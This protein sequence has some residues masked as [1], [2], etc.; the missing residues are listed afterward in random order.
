MYEKTTG[1]PW[2]KPTNAART[3]DLDHYTIGMKKHLAVLVVTF[4]GLPKRPSW[5]HVTCGNI[6][7]IF[8]T[9]EILILFKKWCLVLLQTSIVTPEVC[10]FLLG[11]FFLGVH[12]SSQKIFGLPEGMTFFLATQQ[13]LCV[14]FWA[15][16]YRV[17][18]KKQPSD[19][20]ID[21]SVGSPRAPQLQSCFFRV[22]AIGLQKKQPFML[23]TFTPFQL[24]LWSW[25]WR[26]LRTF[27]GCHVPWLFFLKNP[28]WS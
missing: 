24:Q 13:T 18:H 26:G 11:I 12:T 1:M 2:K 21:S 9:T 6:N 15:L 16:S 7:E 5:W 10:W 25:G 8:R 23:G 17:L 19:R 14:D 4:S 22:V 20:T 28:V 3:W 27:E